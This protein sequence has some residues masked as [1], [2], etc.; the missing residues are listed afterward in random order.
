MVVIELWYLIYA[1]SSVIDFA[2]CISV[3][4]WIAVFDYTKNT[5]FWNLVVL[6]V[7]YLKAVDVALISPSEP[8]LVFPT[9]TWCEQWRNILLHKRNVLMIRLYVSWDIHE[10]DTLILRWLML[11][12]L[13]QLD[14]C[15]ISCLLL[16]KLSWCWTSDI[17]LLSYLA[18]DFTKL[19]LHPIHQQSVSSEK[20]LY[21]V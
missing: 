3:F 15:L 19:R 4:V 17:P 9:D 2:Y 5:T 21:K 20:W 16:A 6:Y 11:T 1:P 18:W 10:I 12:G 8:I 7:N 13:I 14:L